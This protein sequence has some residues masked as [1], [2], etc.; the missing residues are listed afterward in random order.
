MTSVVL[1]IAVYSKICLKRTC[2]KADTCIK[3]TKDFTQKYQFAGQSL[4][5]I[6]VESGHLSIV[7]KNI[8]PQGV[9]FRQVLLESDRARSLD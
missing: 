2:S 7:D 8:S 9:R 3:K 1:C 6:H 4:I 5:N